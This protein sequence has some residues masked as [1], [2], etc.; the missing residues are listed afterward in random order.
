MHRSR[1][2]VAQWLTIL[3]L[4]GVL[5][6]LS[7]AEGPASAPNARQTIQRPPLELQKGRYFRWAAPRGWKSSESTNGVTLEANDKSATVQFALLMRSYGRTTPKDFLLGMLRRVPGYGN[8]R[9]KTLKN[10]PNQPS[11][12]PGTLW[13]I[14]EAELTYTVQGKPVSGIWTCGVNEYYGTY[15]AMLLGYHALQAEWPLARTYLPQV[16]RSIAIHNLRQVAGNDQ[17]IPVR[18]NPLDNSGLIES[19]R[20]KGLSEDRI[21]KARREG[22]SGYERV[23]DPQTGRIYEMPLESYDG[24][25]G[26]YRNPMR[27]NEILQ[28]THPGE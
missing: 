2:A 24:T 13:R 17:L 10:L 6:A 25:V 22:T 7:A 15:D 18:N 21:S 5:P 9:I 20:Q 23:K 8:I 3:F 14:I 1:H 16:A 12:I 28:K 4:V 26:G 11:G 19:W 27:P